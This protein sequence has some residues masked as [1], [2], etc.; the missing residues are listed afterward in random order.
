MFFDETLQRFLFSCL[1][2]LQH[3]PTRSWS[4]AAS[5]ID[6]PSAL[7]AI[8]FWSR[9][10]NAERLRSFQSCGDAGGGSRRRRMCGPA[11]LKSYLSTKVWGFIR[12]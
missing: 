9:L 5:T 7:R 11:G 10:S 8:C 2:Q 12:Q 6:L 3:D 4:F 1:E